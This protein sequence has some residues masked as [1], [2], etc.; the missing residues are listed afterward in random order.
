MIFSFSSLNVAAVQLTWKIREFSYTDDHTK[1]VVVIS[2]D[3]AFGHQ[4]SFSELAE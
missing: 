1:W 4:C 2:F 3:F